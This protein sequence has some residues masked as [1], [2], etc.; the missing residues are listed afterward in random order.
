[1]ALDRLLVIG[2]E[3]LGKKVFDQ[4]LTQGEASRMEDLIDL[5]MPSGI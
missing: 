3:K 4:A 2:K 5:E 1:M